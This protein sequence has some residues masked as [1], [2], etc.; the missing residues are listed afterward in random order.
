MSVS[1]TF[2]QALNI[3][4]VS[5][6]ENRDF[7]LLLTGDDAI[8]SR[9]V[10]FQTERQAS[11]AKIR[12]EYQGVMRK[13][14]GSKKIVRTIP[15]GKE[16]VMVEDVKTGTSFKRE[17]VIF[18][19]GN[20]K[21]DATIL[22]AQIDREVSINAVRKNY[23]TRI[24]QNIGDKKIVQVVPVGKNPL[25]TKAPIVVEVVEPKKLVEA[26]VGLVEPAVLTQMVRK[27]QSVVSWVEGS[28]TSNAPAQSTVIE[29]A[30]PQ[31]ITVR[32]VSTEVVNPQGENTQ[33]T[34]SPSSF[35]TSRIVSG[36]ICKST[37]PVFQTEGIGDGCSTSYGGINLATIPHIGVFK[38]TFTSA[39]NNHDRCYTTL[40]YST[41]KCN[42]DF[43]SD[44]KAAC[45]SRFNRYLQPVEFLACNQTAME[46]KIAVDIFEK[47]ENPGP[48]FQKHLVELGDQVKDAV[49]GGSCFTT[50]ERTNIY[51]PEVVKEVNESFETYSGRKPVVTEFIDAVNTNY[52][53]EKYELNK[54][55]VDEYAKRRAAVKYPEIQVALE[56]QTLKVVNPMPNISYL[57]RIDGYP[58][59]W[60]TSITIPVE[61]IAPKYDLDIPLKGYVTVYPYSKNLSNSVVVDTTIHINGDCGRVS[62]KIGQ[63]GDQGPC[64]LK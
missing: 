24:K 10:Q 13:L 21:S 59:T 4:G 37:I 25:P 30:S 6:P 49:S 53:S 3:N 55:G 36:A 39:C 28:S 43:L 26:P 7:G 52:T 9:T 38:S 41:S 35:S 58:E 60:G 61:D 44:M 50:P 34:K 15:P 11:I 8:D 18:V 16:P 1:A 40:G 64:I 27:I 20:S 29:V 31:I 62:K 23:Q 57:W 51:S 48:S 54:Q 12:K 45:K 63:D 22:Q 46:Y 42:S 33:T 2:A 32:E 5:V 56:D 14:V 17:F 47:E 19:T